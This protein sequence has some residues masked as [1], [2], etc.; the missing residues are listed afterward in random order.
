MKQNDVKIYGIALIAAYSLYRA[1]LFAMSYDPVYPPCTRPSSC[2]HA[3][4][5]EDC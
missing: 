3:E 1:L 5:N 4:C 2:E